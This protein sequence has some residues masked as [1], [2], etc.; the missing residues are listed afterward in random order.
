M[1]AQEIIGQCVRGARGLG[2]ATTVGTHDLIDVFV[3]G[4]SNEEHGKPTQAI[5]FNP[6]PKP[7]LGMVG[8]CSLQPGHMHKRGVGT[9]H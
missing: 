7:G 2:G 8:T 5:R 4:I 6:L 1:R 3:W 9:V